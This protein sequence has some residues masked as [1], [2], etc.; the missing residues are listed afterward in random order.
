M[1]LCLIVDLICDWA[2]NTYRKDII[3]LLSV[4][5]NIVPNRN[6]Y[7]FPSANKAN[8]QAS[9]SSKSWKRNF[10]IRDTNEVFFSFRHLTLPELTNELTAILKPPGL[11]DEDVRQN[12]SKLLG[13]FNLER[14]LLLPTSFI[15]QLETLWTGANNKHPILDSD[16]IIFS[17]ISFQSYFRPSDYHIMREISCITASYGAIDSLHS[18]SGTKC[19]VSSSYPNVSIRLE[20]VLPLT[21]LSGLDSLRAAARNLRLTL[22]VIQKASGPVLPCDWLKHPSQGEFVSSL[23]DNL[24]SCSPGILL[25]PIFG[26]SSEL[27]RMAIASQCSDNSL[28]K[29][30]KQGKSQLPHGAAI[31][32]TPAHLLHPLYPQY[33]LAVFDGYDLDDRHGLGHKLL[34]LI[35]SGSLFE[36]RYSCNVTA[37]DRQFIHDWATRLRGNHG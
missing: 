28:Q 27:R 19:S 9:D 16:E 30:L 23:W 10:V 5:P 26:C 37:Q 3:Q 2:W 11:G 6:C 35:T 12:A 34:Q 21:M 25:F 14:P 22:C 18:L 7:K 17:H 20:K 32:K 1:Q 29:F 33:C 24:E 8:D 13:L 36:G 31:L 15:S 4:G